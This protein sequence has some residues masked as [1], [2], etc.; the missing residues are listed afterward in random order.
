MTATRITHDLLGINS[1]NG[2]SRAVPAGG[3]QES[4]SQFEKG[5]T[6]SLRNLEM[7]MDAI[8]PISL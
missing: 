2:S 1:L 7:M 3:K 8:Y 4:I 5:K 6:I